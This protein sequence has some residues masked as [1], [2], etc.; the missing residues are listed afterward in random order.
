MMMSIDE[1]IHAL[2]LFN[3][4][5]IMT[6]QNKTK[7]ILF[8][9]VFVFCFGLLGFFSFIVLF[10]FVIIFFCFSFFVLHAG[11]VNL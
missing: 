3:I 1:L 5:I 9:S 7:R 4:I 6:I 2:I 10:N 8:S 11:I